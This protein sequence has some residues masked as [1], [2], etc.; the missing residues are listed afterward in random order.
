MISNHSRK[1]AQIL[2]AALLL[3]L[4]VAGFGA[5]DDGFS[6]DGVPVDA[7]DSAGSGSNAAMGWM[8]SP[9]DVQLELIV[10]ALGVVIVAGGLRNPRR[11]MRDQL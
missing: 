3:M 7:A 4:L 9:P 2:R 5:C 10:V 1:V 11:R 8:A 6:R